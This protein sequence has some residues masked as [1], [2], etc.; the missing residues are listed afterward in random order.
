[1]NYEETRQAA[2]MRVTEMGRVLERCGLRLRDEYTLDEAMEFAGKRV[3]ELIDDGY[4]GMLSLLASRSHAGRRVSDDVLF[5]DSTLPLTASTLER[6]LRNVSALA[7]CPLHVSNLRIKYD[8]SYRPHKKRLIKRDNIIGDVQFDLPDAPAKWRVP[9]AEDLPISR[10][11]NIKSARVGDTVINSPS[12]EWQM[13]VS[14]V[15]L[16]SHISECLMRCGARLKLYFYEVDEGCYVIAKL[17]GEIFEIKVSTGLAFFPVPE[18]DYD[19]E[20]YERDD[21]LARASEMD[22]L[23]SPDTDSDAEG[24]AHEGGL[25]HDALKALAQKPLDEIDK[26]IAQAF[27]TSRGSG[28]EG[29]PKIA[30]APSGSAIA[31]PLFGEDES[32]EL[33]P[34][35][36]EQ[37]GYESEAG[38]VNVYDFLDRFA[39]GCARAFMTPHAR[40][41]LRERE[42]LEVRD[43]LVQLAQRGLRMN[44]GYLLREV[45]KSEGIRPTRLKR[46]GWEGLIWFL[47]GVDKVDGEIKP[48]SDDI[49]LYDYHDYHNRRLLIELTRSIQRMTR[50]GL[51]FGSVT[52]HNDK[53]GRPSVFEFVQGGKRHHWRLRT[54]TGG[55]QLTDYFEHMAE[56]MRDNGCEGNLWYFERRSK[57]YYMY[58]TARNGLRLRKLTGLPLQPVLRQQ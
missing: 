4:A 32:V 53:S 21:E 1:M 12:D 33:D 58:V 2:L 45:I 25:S 46:M 49:L 14:G 44:T 35:L 48:Y 15:K 7:K 40:A 31:E 56:L 8:V 36:V 26:L 29:L 30:A 18:P 37:L 52:Q 34:E 11:P 23:T 55:A 43:Q 50:G 6:L 24:D 54:D 5:V 28:A 20:L 51:H 19:D 17:P 3:L 47:C 41:E 39:Q 38:R 42:Y 10:I 13:R 27:S 16:L 9:S 22:A 57:C